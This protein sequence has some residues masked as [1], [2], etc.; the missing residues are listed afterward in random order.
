MEKGKRLEK[1][2]YL[3]FVTFDMPCWNQHQFG[4]NIRK[5]SQTYQTLLISA[6]GNYIFDDRVTRTPRERVKKIRE[7]Q[8]I[9]LPP[10]GYT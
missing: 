9:K 8:L 10:F 2:K 5:T 7:S 6:T 4:W 3:L 1:E